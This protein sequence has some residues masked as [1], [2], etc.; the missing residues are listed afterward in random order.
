MFNPI[1]KKIVPYLILATIALFIV[2]F[3]FLRSD[4]YFWLLIWGIVTYFAWQYY[5]RQEGRVLFWVGIVAFSIMMLSTFLFRFIL[6]IIVVIVGLYFYQMKENKKRA[7]QQLQF[8]EEPLEEE[9]LLFSNRWF[10]KQQ[11]GAK[12]YQWQDINCQ[13]LF[14]QTII[15]LNQTVLPKGEP[16]LVL[17]HLV[18]TITLI[19]PYDVEVSI[20][21]SVL[22]GSVDI[23]GYGDDRIVN[24]TVHYRTKNYQ[25]APQRIKIYTSMIAG[26]IEVRRG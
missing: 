13:T 17:H 2:E 6:A 8:G 16:T 4:A 23:F 19:I 18:G 1:D 20:H 10:G 11:T 22:A 12:P 7:P 5:Y 3:V 9:E 26:Q 24:R 14:G 21:H 25:T 15:N